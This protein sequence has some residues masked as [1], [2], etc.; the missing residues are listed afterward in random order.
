MRV[1]V[2]M[3]YVNPYELLGVT[4]TSPKE[5]VRRAYYRLA[6][7][8][9][10][11]KGGYDKDMH[12]LHSAY[13]WIM[14]HLDVVASRE[15]GAETY[16]E[17]EES[18]KA[19][20]DQQ[21]S[22]NYKVRSVDEIVKEVT[23]FQDQIFEDLFAEM[24]SQR[25]QENGFY[26][27]TAKTHVMSQLLHQMEFSSKIDDKRTTRDMMRDLLKQY[28]SMVLTS[29]I[30]DSTIPGGYGYCM[31]KSQPY[32]EMDVCDPPIAPEMSFG[33]QEIQVYKE[34]AAIWAPPA[35]A[36]N[37]IGLPKKLDDYTMDN[38]TDYVKAFQDPIGAL[39]PWETA[40]KEQESTELSSALDAMVLER[41]MADLAQDS[42]QS[43]QRSVFLRFHDKPKS[44]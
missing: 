31:E 13:E 22:Q 17:K 2:V 7:I 39:G 37:C 11:D 14:N 4:E 24:A 42:Q 18:F 33:K 41:K 12:I 21:L 29:G 30:F 9:H 28:L 19:F 34:P 25:V 26:K 36:A 1:D 40:A 32:E 5:D 44:T 35:Q 6:M 10:P 8:V 20:L 43:S 38:M 27:K 23:Q 16:E 3:T 15:G